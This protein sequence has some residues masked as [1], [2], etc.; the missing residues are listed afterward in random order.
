MR[1]I[2]TSVIAPSKEKWDKFLK[3][4]LGESF[5]MISSYSLGGTH[6]AVFAHLSI[7]PIISDVHSECL[8]TGI[9]NMVG[10][11]GAVGIRMN[12]GKTS[13]LCISCHL[14]AGQ[15]K[16][17]NRNEDFMQIH[18]KLVMREE[19]E[20]E[21]SGNSCMG[22]KVKKSV[23]AIHKKPIKRNMVAAV[24]ESLDREDSSSLRAEQAS[25][26]VSQMS[27]DCVIWMGDFNY[28]VNGVIGAVVHA[29][30]KNMYEVLLD[31]D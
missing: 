17:D 16:V 15:E 9:K 6:L 19:P 11:K 21:E 13:L 29:M 4:Y 27:T 1:S 28:R 26:W 31:N 22:T 12:I 23:P 24:S 25:S 5:V 20:E 8:A 30:K 14:A 7:T 2:A 3:E 18:K 10:N